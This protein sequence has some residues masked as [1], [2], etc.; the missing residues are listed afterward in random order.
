M[1]DGAQPGDQPPLGEPT[2]ALARPRSGSWYGNPLVAAALGLLA[3]L[4]AGFGIGRSL[5]QGSAE[6]TSPKPVPTRPPVVTTTV[7]PPP[8]LPADCDQALR[9]AEDVVQLLEHGFQ[10][11]R[12]LQVDRVEQVVAEL[13]RLRSEVTARVVGCQEQLRR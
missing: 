11:L 12:R 3:G 6:E 4:V 1:T 7:P 8:T 9:S 5:D 10:N 13:A 2:P